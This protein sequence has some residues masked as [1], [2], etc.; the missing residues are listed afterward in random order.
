MLE[1]ESAMLEQELLEQQS[2]PRYIHRR[3]ILCLSWVPWNSIL[4]LCWAPW[5]SRFCL[6]LC[7]FHTTSWH[8]CDRLSLGRPR[9]RPPHLMMLSVLSGLYVCVR[10]SRSLSVCRSRESSS[11]SFAAHAEEGHGHS[12]ERKQSCL[13]QS[14]WL[15]GAKIQRWWFLLMPRGSTLQTTRQASWQSLSN[16]LPFSHKKVDIVFVIATHCLFKKNDQR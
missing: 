8:T 11:S 3:S 9:F 13:R 15:C 6:C 4:C 14:H 2:V 7:L 16:V 10:L 12:K 5:N 1:Q